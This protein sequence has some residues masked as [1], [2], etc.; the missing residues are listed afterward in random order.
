MLFISILIDIQPDQNSYDVL[1]CENL[2][3]DKISLIKLYRLTF[4]PV[5]LTMCVPP[6]YY[7]TYTNTYL[8]YLVQYLLLNA[9]L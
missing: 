7:S 2:D 1:I 8:Q 4:N 6:F 3:F 9:S 5:M